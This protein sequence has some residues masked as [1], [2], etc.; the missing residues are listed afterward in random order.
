MKFTSTT[1]LCLAYAASSSFAFSPCRSRAFVAPAATC[2]LAPALHMSE[3]AVEKKEEETFD[4]QADVGRVMDIIINSLYS[5]RD[6]FLRELVSNAADACDKKRFLSIT[7]EDSKVAGELPSIKIRGDPENNVIILEDTGVGMTKDELKNNLGKIA[8]SGTRN[9]ADALGKGGDDSVN[10]IG[11]FGVGFYSAYLIADKVEVITKSMQEGSPVYRWE[12]DSCSSFTISEVENPDEDLF[13]GASSG[14]RLILHLKDDAMQYAESSKL[15]ELLNH[16][17][18]FIEYPISIYK[19]TTEYEKVLDVE[20]NADLKEGDE[21]KMKTVP[22]TKSDYELLNSQ[23]PLWLRS[24]K[25]V[26]EEEYKEFYK[27]A[28]RASYDEPQKWTHFSLEGQIECKALL[29]VPGMLPFELSK[30]MFDENARNIRL[31]VKRVFINDKFE[32]IM[33]RWLKFVRGIVD[34]NDLPLNVSREILQKSKVLSII[35]KR[36]VRKSLDMFRDLAADEDSSKYTMFW[37]N[38]GKYL[39]VGVIEDDRNR[40]DIVPL[41]RFQSSKSGDEYT[42]LDKYV[43]GMAEGQK[44]IYYVTGDGKENVEMSPVI[45][46]LTSKG[47]EVLYSTEPVDEITM[48]SISEYKDFKLVDS[49]KEGLDFEEDEDSKKQKS[50]LEEQYADVREFLESQLVGKI[51]KVSVSTLL[52]NSPAA[53]VQSAYGMS[54]TMQRYMKAQ[55]V[56]QGGNTNESMNQAVLEINPNHPIIQD[57]NSMIKGKQEEEETKNFAMLIYD[58]ASMTSGYD[59]DD[60]SNFAQRVMSLMSSSSQETGVVQE[61]EVVEPLPVIEDDEPESIK[62]EV[63]AE[64]AAEVVAEVVEPSSKIEDDDEPEAIKPEVVA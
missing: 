59:I 15:D 27:A 20:A 2:R 18:E 1:L 61:A 21:P 63:A 62:P 35:N 60:A 13:D 3:A 26:E 38:F 4:F 53:L 11:Q 19:E 39:K 34:S 49:S 57:L 31:Y 48:E 42:S 25:E 47:Y 58:V 7:S 52:T 9:F 40:N 29:Y 8:Q 6:I 17:S 56:A 30:D 64:V 37:N 55:A 44:S 51:N 54:P 46:K 10:L 22:T 14:S 32:D 43:E 33:P 45:E 36:L 41:L 24:P 23:K 5:D 50:D 28:F 12:S 16:Y